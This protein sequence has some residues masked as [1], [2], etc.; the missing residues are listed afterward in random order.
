MSASEIRCQLCGATFA[1]HPGRGR[2][3]KYCVECASRKN[4]QP[5]QP[6]GLRDITCVEC[7]DHFTARTLAAKLC[8]RRCKDR[9]YARLHPEM[10]AE[11]KRRKSRRRKGLE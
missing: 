2:P 9:R 8:S 7:G 1:A 6:V 11:K 10:L 5:Y 3:R 4:R